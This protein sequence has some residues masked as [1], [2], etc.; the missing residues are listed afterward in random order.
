MAKGNKSNKT[1]KKSTSK[2]SSAKNPT[3]S[4]GQ[5][6]SQSKSQ[7]QMPV[8]PVTI[9]GQYIKDLSFETP[10]PF[11][12]A[13]SSKESPS[14]NLNIEVKAKPMA[15]NRFE[16]ELQITAE[17]TRDSQRAFMLELTYAGAFTLQNI[18]EQNIPPVLLIECPRLLFPFARAIVAEVTRD[19]GFPPLSLA[20][21]DFAEIY[22]RQVQKAQEQQGS[23]SATQS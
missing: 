5:S 23:K 22:R 19:G 4:Q 16:V 1:T 11:Q 7:G 13:G 20:P 14:I 17:A 3:Q 15:D 18:P 10:G 12:I 9:H 8:L 2:K 6:Q 21:I